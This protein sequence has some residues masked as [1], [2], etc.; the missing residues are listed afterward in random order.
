ML[1]AGLAVGS[2]ERGF[3]LI[4]PSFSIRGTDIGTSYRTSPSLAIAR[5]G[6][7]RFYVDLNLSSTSVVS[8]LTV[9]LQ[10][11]FDDGVNRTL[12]FDLPSTN[13]DVAGTSE[14]EHTFITVSGTRQTFGFFLPDSGIGNLTVSVKAN[15]AGSIGD[16]VTVY[17]ETS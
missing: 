7:V 6:A 16:S 5:S 9:K 17:G 4:L 8:R 13:G 10:A 12:P 3:R 15:K 11:L 2:G 14:I 1:A